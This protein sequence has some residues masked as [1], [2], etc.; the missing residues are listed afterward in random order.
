MVV[1]D[2][3]DYLT[4]PLS[5]ERIN[6]KF[7][8]KMKFLEYGNIFSLIKNHFEWKDIPETREPQPRNS[9]LNKILTMDKKGCV[10]PSSSITPKRLSDSM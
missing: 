3:I 4:V 8:V 2:F 5:S 10:K 6:N 9:F 7:E 1:S